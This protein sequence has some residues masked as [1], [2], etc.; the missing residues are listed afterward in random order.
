M[1]FWWYRLL[2]VVY[3][4]EHQN[5]A[6]SPSGSLISCSCSVCQFDSS[7]KICRGP[8]DISSSDILI[9][10]QCS[11]RLHSRI[12]YCLT[13]WFF[14]AQTTLQIRSVSCAF[15]Q[16]VAQLDD[17]FSK[18]IEW[19]TIRTIPSPVK[20]SPRNSNIIIGIT[21]IWFWSH[22]AEKRRI[23]Q[24]RIA[25]I[26]QIILETRWIGWHIRFD[27]KFPRFARHLP[28]AEHSFSMVTPLA[29]REYLNFAHKERVT[30]VKKEMQMSPSGPYSHESANFK[31]LDYKHM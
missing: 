8:C 6:R 16:E 11:E 26:E 15:L 22:D 3:S 29:S 13:N 27:T 4:R 21:T 9:G 31:L 20:R 2:F 18:N 17:I 12:L 19:R 24:I 25:G 10:I 28:L 5:A 7:S 1:F 23:H 14:L 30:K